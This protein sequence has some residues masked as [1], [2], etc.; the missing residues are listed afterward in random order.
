MTS[1]KDARDFM[2]RTLANTWRQAIRLLT[3]KDTMD[4]WHKLMPLF[5]LKME[6]TAPD[7][8]VR[9]KPEHLT[10]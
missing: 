2:M 1:G 9:I 7:N 10:I 8:S 6:S 3:P 5:Q 4:L